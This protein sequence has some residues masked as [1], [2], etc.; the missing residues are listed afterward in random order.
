MVRNL[1]EEAHLQPGEKVLDVGC[2]TGVLD[3]WLYRHTGGENRITAVDF[4]P[5]LLREAIELT[6]KERLD[7]AIEYR[8]GNAEA[9]PFPANSFDVTMSVTVIEEVQANQMLAEIVRVTR[10]GG[11]VSVVARALDMP[12]TINLPLRL[13]TK[14]KAESPQGGLSEGGCADA[15]LYL[16]FYGTN[17]THVRIFPHHCA[18]GTKP[19]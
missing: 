17:L 15:S 14:A 3:R 19:S 1:V 5:Y 16:C 6:R 2:G 11:R 7:A 12:F 10:P 9:M 13:E 8:E 18:I 4:S